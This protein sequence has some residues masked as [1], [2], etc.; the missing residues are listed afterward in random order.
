MGGVNSFTS[1]AA[2]LIRVLP[3]LCRS[4]SKTAHNPPKTILSAESAIHWGMRQAVGLQPNQIAREPRA[5]PWAGMN[6]ALGLKPAYSLDADSG[7]S[8][9]PVQAGWGGRVCSCGVTPG[10]SAGSA[11]RQR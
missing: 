5:L 2:I 9:N 7:A 10:D 3:P 1:Q 6:Q 4:L 11:L 8:L